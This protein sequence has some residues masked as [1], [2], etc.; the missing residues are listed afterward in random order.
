M[1]LR[2]LSLSL[3]YEYNVSS[4]CVGSSH[5]G[6]SHAL[7]CA[8]GT[9][10]VEARYADA[11]CEGA[12][13]STTPLAPCAASSSAQVAA[14][15]WQGG[16]IRN[17]SVLVLL[18][19]LSDA[20]AASSFH[21]VYLP[22]FSGYKDPSVNSRFNFDEE[23][24]NGTGLAWA[25]DGADARVYERLFVAQWGRACHDTPGEGPPTAGAPVLETDLP[26]PSPFSFLV[27]QYL[28]PQTATGPAKGA[29][30]RHRALVFDKL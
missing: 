10:P 9:T 13:T 27:R 29:L 7:F 5:D 19:A 12:A 22:V 17:A 18:G 6:S 11:H 24:L 23:R 28:D 25:P 30:P 15:C 3:R 16:Y 21:N 20:L 4:E 8:N 14:A 2:P 1:T 26:S